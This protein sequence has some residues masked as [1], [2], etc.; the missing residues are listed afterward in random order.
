MAEEQSSQEKTEEATPKRLREA[1]KKGQVAHSK[2]LMTV[3]ILICAFTTL[4]YLIPFIYKEFQES[5]L[6]CIAIV[7][8]QNINHRDVMQFLT[9]SFMVFVKIMTPYL[10]ILFVIS[11]ATGFFQVGPVFSTEPLKPQAKRLNIIE[12]VKNMCKVTTLIELVKNIVKIFI[13]FY[14]A[15]VVVKK[16]LVPLMLT[17]TLDL[18]Q[19]T[20]VAGE[21]I[22]GFLIRVFVIFVLIAIID[23]MVQRWQY[24]KQLR[25]TKE[26]VK[27][28]YK[29]DEGDP[30]IKSVR[31]QLHQELAMGDQRKA[32][33]AS[34]V[35]I[36][37]PT[38]L[39]IAVKYDDKEMMAPTIMTKGQRLFAQKIRDIAEEEG[40][41]IIRNVPLAWSLIEVEVGQEIPEELYQAI[42]EVL[43]IIYKMK[44]QQEKPPSL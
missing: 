26:E 33:A 40:V 14:M 23:I 27:R 7:S 6:G 36:T 39:A 43:V 25:M 15:Y 12:N 4:S 11:V 37:N 5:I 2:D 24:K 41:P 28:E 10:L 17:S 9:Q 22:S 21:I 29:Q 13:V 3:V 35:V 18:M 32:V 34:D 20:R 1:R 19:S 8:K 16:N 42:A 38:E 44:D 31:R 30:I